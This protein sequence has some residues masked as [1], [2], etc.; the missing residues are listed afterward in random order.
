ML[1]VGYG[2]P[3]MAKGR[4]LFGKLLFLAESRHLRLTPYDPFGSPVS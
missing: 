3:R 1:L 4:D 2:T